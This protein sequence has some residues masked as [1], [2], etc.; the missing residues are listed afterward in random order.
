MNLLCE[1]FCYLINVPS[2]VSCTRSMSL[3]LGL[4]KDIGIQQHTNIFLTGSYSHK[5]AL[6]WLLVGFGYLFS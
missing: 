5:Q 4:Q 1:F 6:V 2:F 3:I